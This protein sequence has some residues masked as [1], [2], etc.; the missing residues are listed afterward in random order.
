M[1]DSTHTCNCVHARRRFLAVGSA[2]TVFA[3]LHEAIAQT[4]AIR[5]LSPPKNCSA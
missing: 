1:A 4:E 2:A 5:R 3:S